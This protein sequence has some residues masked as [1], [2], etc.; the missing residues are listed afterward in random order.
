MTTS[1][2]TVGNRVEKKNMVEKASRIELSEKTNCTGAELSASI[3]GSKLP[4][5]PSTKYKINSVSDARPATKRLVAAIPLAV[6]PTER[7]M[8]NEARNLSP[9]RTELS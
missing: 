8:L 4:A 6:S 7:C 3:S 2:S 9:Q 1:S 5:V